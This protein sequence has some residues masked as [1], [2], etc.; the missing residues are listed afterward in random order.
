MTIRMKLSGLVIGLC[1]LVSACD[2]GQGGYTITVT[3]EN[4]QN[5]QN[6]PADSAAP[7][8]QASGDEGSGGTQ[9]PNWPPVKDGQ[10]IEM[11]DNFL[12][13][14]YY[15]ILDASGSMSYT[16]GQ[17]GGEKRID[18]A[19]KAVTAFLRELPRDV[20]LG[21]LAFQPTRELVPLGPGTHQEVA[22]QVQRLIPQGKTPLHRAMTMGY[23]ALENQAR[24][25]SGYGTYK[26]IV[27]TDGESNDNDPGP[28]ARAIVNSSPVEV[29]VIGFAIAD[30]ALNI[31]GITRY[32]TANSTEELVKALTDTTKSESESFDVLSFE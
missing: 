3:P 16:V 9:A 8:T 31:P 10:R 22:E 11:A 17:Y 20:N 21:L 28:L 12:A 14:N 23:A 26:L 2:P 25:Q 19:K 18:A 32:V 5:T 27:V 30:H 4:N 6:N 29:H 1:L 15:I 7:Q 24:R 13:E